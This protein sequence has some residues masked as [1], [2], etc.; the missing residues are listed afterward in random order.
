MF[1]TARNGQEYLL[2]SQFIQS[3]YALFGENETKTYS[4]GEAAMNM[5]GSSFDKEK[6][7]WDSIMQI[8]R[9][10]ASNQFCDLN[11]SLPKAIKTI[12][13][14]LGSKIATE[15][16]G[17][18]ADSME[19]HVGWKKFVGLAK[20]KEVGNLIVNAIKYRLHSEIERCRTESRDDYLF[21]SDLSDWLPNE[22]S[23]IK[24]SKEFANEMATMLGYTYKQYRA[25]LSLLRSKH[26]FLPRL[27]SAK[28]WDKIDYS[29]LTKKEIDRHHNIF[30]SHDQE[31]Y[32]EF[33][34]NNKEKLM[35]VDLIHN[36]DDLSN[37]ATRINRNCTSIVYP[38]TVL[39]NHERS[40]LDNRFFNTYSSILRCMKKMLSSQTRSKVVNPKLILD[41]NY[42]SSSFVDLLK[43]TACVNNASFELE[44]R[45]LTLGSKYLGINLL[46]R[47]GLEDILSFYSSNHR[48]KNFSNLLVV[49]KGS[50]KARY[51]L[52]HDISYMVYSGV[53][54]K[55]KEINKPIPSISVWN[56]GYDIYDSTIYHLT[57]EGRIILKYSLENVIQMMLGNLSVDYLGKSIIEQF[58]Q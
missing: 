18:A 16:I 12:E 56:I 14:F 36:L 43:T 40:D 19:T 54:D 6:G 46:L 20:N 29:I 57:L 39:M 44:S 52:E 48:S 33:V 41:S 10:M 53:V 28:E 42:P 13:R 2:D 51:E 8:F 45:E 3:L 47:R 15:W 24:Y 50:E 37:N 38:I 58:C 49:I 30:M 9:F 26:Q 25:I 23:K 27:M 4:R 55:F 11:E 21:L 7:N 5:M 1:V 22:N 31:R 17:I 32:L 34:N 35:A